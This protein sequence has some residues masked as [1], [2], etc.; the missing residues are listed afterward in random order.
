MYIGTF[1]DGKFNGYGLMFAEPSSD[2]TNV[3]YNLSTRGIGDATFQNFNY[4]SVNY[5]SFEGEFEDG[6]PN[7]EGNNF[8]CSLYYT[9][10]ANELMGKN[11]LTLDDIGYQ[12][13]VG[14]FKDGEANG[15]VR[16][17]RS[18]IL[19]YDGEMRN[20]KREGKGIQYQDRSTSV[21]YE[22]EFKNDQ[23]NGSGILY[24][25]NGQIVYD[26]K[27]KNGDFA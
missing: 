9:A 25:E 23:Y 22:G 6:M 11:N 14:E 8:Y 3:L 24:D 4:A 19:N 13:T 18:G 10:L 15:D 7:G 5:V 1:E 26:G 20:N 17:Y 16:V 27:W 2:D 21:L 12:I